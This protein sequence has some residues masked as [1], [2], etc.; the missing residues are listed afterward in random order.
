MR[1]EMPNKRTQPVLYHTTIRNC[2]LVA[3]IATTGFRRKTVSQLDYTGAES[4]HLIM[5]DDFVVLDVPRHF[6]KNPDSPFFGPK[7]KESDY[8]DRLPNYF[9]LVDIFSEYLTSSRPFILDRYRPNREEQPLFVMAGGS[10]N[11]RMSPD[12]VTEIYYKAA[13]R[14]LVGNRWR[15]TGIQNVWPSGPHSARHIRGTAVVKKTGSFLLAG[16]A[17]HN[18]E[19]MAYEHYARVTTQDRN[20]RARVALFGEDGEV[21]TAL[22]ARGSW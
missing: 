14:H 20:S 12:S 6:F 18:S 2:A 3:L 7:G 15:G 11:A 5:Q 13:G 16:Y 10:K 9:W 17:N 4:G 19:R 21:N 22:T 8:N 1:D